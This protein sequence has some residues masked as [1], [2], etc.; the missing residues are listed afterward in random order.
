M[1]N[2]ENTRLSERSQ[3]QKTTEYMISYA[4]YPEQTNPQR[5]KVDQQLL[6]GGAVSGEKHLL[7][8]Y[9]GDENVLELDNVMALQPYQYIKNH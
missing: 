5:Q 2:L 8:G 9:R 3:T 1:N 7:M 6:V 4:K